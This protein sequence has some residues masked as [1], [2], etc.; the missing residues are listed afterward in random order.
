MIPPSDELVPCDTMNGNFVIIPA[1]VVTKI[2]NLDPMYTHAFG[3]FDY[4]LRA[5]A[6]DCKIWIAPGYYGTCARNPIEG[7]WQDSRLSLRQRIR[8]I[9]S[10]KGLPVKEWRIFARK[11]AGFF[12]PV[13]WLS[14]YVRFFISHLKAKY[15]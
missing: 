13:Y 7:S 2:G 10:V 5:K 3:D 9:N 6:K 8:K 12:W 14:P 1:A 4:G 15:N 11:Y